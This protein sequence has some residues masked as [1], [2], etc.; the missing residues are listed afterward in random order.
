[1]LKVTY[2][3]HFRFFVF[4]LESLQSS[5]T[6]SASLKAWWLCVFCCCIFS[7][8][9][10]ILRKCSVFLSSAKLLLW[11]QYNHKHHTC[12]YILPWPSKHVQPDWNCCRHTSFQNK[13]NAPASQRLG[14]RMFQ[15][16]GKLISA[17]KNRA[18][19]SSWS[20]LCLPL[21]SP[22]HLQ[23]EKHGAAS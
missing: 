1:M 13:N 22:V 5:D 19:A 21:F 11:S 17:A 7:L 18:T 14:R 6:L 12:G 3:A 4:D 8:Y 15:K 2:Y 20:S 16:T 10:C 9:F 23:A